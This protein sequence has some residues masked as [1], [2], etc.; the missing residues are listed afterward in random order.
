MILIQDGEIFIS[1][2]DNIRVNNKRH[3]SLG[4]LRLAIILP[5]RVMTTRQLHE[6]LLCL[7]DPGRVAVHAAQD[8]P[9]GHKRNDGGA[10]VPMW[11]SESI[12]WVLQLDGHDGFSWCILEFVVI[13]DCDL[14]SGSGAASILVN[15][16]LDSYW[17]D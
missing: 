4:P 6:V 5:D 3:N 10:T 14:F 1:V 17:L 8:A 16:T 15:M 12:R 7:V 2:L 9:L 13:Q 11:R